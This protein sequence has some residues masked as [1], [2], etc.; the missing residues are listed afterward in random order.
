MTQS[1]NIVS[2]RPPADPPLVDGYDYKRFSAVGQALAAG[3]IDDLTPE[4]VEWY[5]TVASRLEWVLF[6]TRRDLRGT[7]ERV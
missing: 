6:Q 5:V 7:L 4:A 3:R 2:G 1:A